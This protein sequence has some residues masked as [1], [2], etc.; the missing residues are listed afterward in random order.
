MEDY[1]INDL[2]KNMISQEDVRNFYV[3]NEELPKKIYERSQLYYYQFAQLANEGIIELLSS[4]WLNST[5]HVN[6]P[7]IKETVHNKFGDLMGYDGSFCLKFVDKYLIRIIKTTD[8]IINL[9]DCSFDFRF[10]ENNSNSMNAFFTIFTDNIKDMMIE[11]ANEII[12]QMRAEEEA[13]KIYNIINSKL[14]K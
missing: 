14:L 13:K 10:F 6:N 11:Q 8:S 5:Y 4:E 1:I 9:N 2:V 3:K 12:A 7:S